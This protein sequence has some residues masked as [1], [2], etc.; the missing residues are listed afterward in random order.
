MARALARR[1]GGKAL[2][3]KGGQFL[4]FQGNNRKQVD[5]Y[6]TCA[7]ALFQNADP[8]SQL[9]ALDEKF[10]RTGASPIEGLWEKPA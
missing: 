1:F 5:V 7:Q 9:P 3:M 8:L 10:D 6:L 4:N 2:G